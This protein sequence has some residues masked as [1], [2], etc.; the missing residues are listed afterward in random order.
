MERKLTEDQKQYLLDLKHK[1][2]ED[3][4]RYKEIIKD[5]LLENDILIYL[6]HNETLEQNDAENDDYY[7]IN[8]KPQYHIPET[9]SDVQNYV[10]FEVSFDDTAKYNTAI[11]LQQIIFY[12]LCDD[13][14]ILV[15]DIGASRHDL[16][17]ALLIDEF[18]GSNLFGNQLKL[19]SDK[20]G[21]TDNN[22]STRTLIFEQKTINSLTKADGQTFN[23]RR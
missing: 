23:L 14:D 11:K 10:C 2:N 12:I 20:P 7:G 22:Y 16:I 1:P 21:A 5:R 19:V 4:V 17:G 9:Q 13:K 6:L 18:Q 3:I 15:K 8:I